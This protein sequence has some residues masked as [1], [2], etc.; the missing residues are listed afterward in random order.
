MSKHFLLAV[1]LSLAAF[2]SVKA[3]PIPEPKPEPIDLVLCLDTSGSMN[4]LIDSAKL[5]LWDVVNE[6]KNIEPAPLLRVALYSYGHSSLDPKT[7]WVNEEIGLT[8]DLDD[9]YAK[10]NG[11]KTAGGTEYVARVGMAA[12]TDQKWATSKNG[13]RIVFICGNEAATQDPKVTLDALTKAANKNDVIVNTIY[14]HPANNP[15]AQG[16]QTLAQ[17]AG[18]AYANIDQNQASR[19]FAN[20]IKTPVDAKLSE[21][22]TKLNSTY[23][24]YGSRGIEKLASQSAQDLSAK[25]AAPSAGFARA[26]TKATAFYRNTTWDLVDKM[27]N[28]K[29]FDITKMKKEELPKEMQDLKPKERVVYIEKK[30]EER[31]TISEQ[32]TKLYAQRQKIVEKARKEQPK[33]DADKAL[34][35]ALKTMIRNQAK[36]KGFVFKDAKK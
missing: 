6:L 7:G 8:D 36:A 18:G 32:I 4:G 26:Q 22:N 1:G 20:T 25:E 12:I 13:L 10:L 23:V 29:K 28:D 17:T 14:C 31:K 2:T 5:K 15:L 27:K 16:W 19:D 24:A 33:T 9:V 35:E 21:L 11:L 3:A 34:D 30:A